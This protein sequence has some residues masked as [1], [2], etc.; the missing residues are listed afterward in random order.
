MVSSV[1]YTGLEDGQPFVA[2]AHV[3]RPPPLVIHAPPASGF[4]ASNSTC[5][6]SYLKTP[7]HCYMAATFAIYLVFSWVPNFL[8]LDTELPFLYFC[9]SPK[10]T[11]LL[12]LAHR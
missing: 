5:S 12:S 8:S 10:R 11:F 4:A 6:I 9:S 7:R 3:I 1:F 2:V